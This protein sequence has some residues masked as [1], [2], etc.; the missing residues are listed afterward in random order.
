MGC[1]CCGLL[2]W[3][4]RLAPSGQ[5]AVVRFGAGL[6]LRTQKVCVVL[7]SGSRCT[8]LSGIVGFA[9]AVVRPQARAVYLGALLCYAVLWN[10]AADTTALGLVVH[11]CLNCIETVVPREGVALPATAGVTWC[12]RDVC[13]RITVRGCEQQ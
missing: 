7:L 2:S 5:Q 10:A 11:V 6:L 9:S 13:A 1:C 3:V 12:A 4:I 8:C